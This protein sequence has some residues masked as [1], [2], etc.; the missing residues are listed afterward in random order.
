MRTMF[1]LVAS[2]H[3]TDRDRN[4]ASGRLEAA[5]LAPV[6]IVFALVKR[7]VADPPTRVMCEPTRVS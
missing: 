3:K 7:L 5:S 4:P 2:G 1:Y 6:P